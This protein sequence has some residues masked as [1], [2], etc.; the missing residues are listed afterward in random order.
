MHIGVQKHALIVQMLDENF[1]SRSLCQEVGG[2]RRF[3]MTF[4]KKETENITS[5]PGIQTCQ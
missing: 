1:T 5:N 2:R 3:E 4:W